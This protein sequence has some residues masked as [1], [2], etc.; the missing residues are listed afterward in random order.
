[1]HLSENKIKILSKIFS[2]L[3][4]DN[5]SNDIRL[6]IGELIISLLNAQ[7]F[8]SFIWNGEKDTFDY[9]VTINMSANNIGNYIE[10]YQFNDPITT[11]LQ[12][13]RKSTLVTD[14]IAHDDLKKTEFFNDFLI[15][16]GLFWGINF[17]AWN[18]YKN[19]G[20]LRIWRDVKRGNF[21]SD[22]VILLDMIGSAFTS[23]LARTNNQEH[24]YFPNISEGN[25][26][27]NLS[28]REQS[29]ATLITRGYSD[30]EIAKQLCISPTTVRTHINNAFEKMNVSKRIDFIKKLEYKNSKS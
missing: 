30:K 28:P 12:T 3:S 16:D 15:V 27:K 17:Y 13:Q 23:F 24:N 19:I 2:I 10:Y 6:T 18:N 4:G 22:D 8:A 1:M 29:I 25:I 7:F 26:I 20:D 9:S 21:S 14:V 11:K 5:S